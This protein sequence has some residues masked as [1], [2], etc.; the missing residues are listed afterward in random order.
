MSSKLTLLTI[1]FPKLRILWCSS[2]AETAEIFDEL[3]SGCQQ[4]NAEDAQKIKTDQV[5]ENDDYKFNPILKDILLKIPGINSKNINA[6][7][8]KVNTL[9]DLCKMSEDELNALLENSKNAKL[10]FEF[11]NKTVKRADGDDEYDK[12]DFE[13]LDDFYVENNNG[14]EKEPTEETTA[15]SSGG[16]LLKLS[17]KTATKPTSKSTKSRTKKK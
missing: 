4:P 11:L 7:F 14:K 8:S 2:C 5:I 12:L 16:G 15:S 3:K 10:V 17:K 13:D 1:H 6:I 9:Q